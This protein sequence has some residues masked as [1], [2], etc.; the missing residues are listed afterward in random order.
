[1]EDDAKLYIAALMNMSCE[2]LSMWE[3]TSKHGYVPV[4]RL[5]QLDKYT[6]NFEHYLTHDV[7]V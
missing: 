2:V 1:M 7:V 6:L 4:R 3:Y 5:D